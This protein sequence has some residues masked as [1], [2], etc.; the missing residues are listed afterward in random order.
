[1]TPNLEGIA[2]AFDP[3]INKIITTTYRGL[4]AVDVVD[5]SVSEYEVWD[6]HAVTSPS[7]AG[8]GT[9]YFG[10]EGVKLL[11]VSYVYLYSIYRPFG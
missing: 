3:R 2:T 10:C 9:I 7:I 5:G 4:A 1:M 6:C 11:D 8:D